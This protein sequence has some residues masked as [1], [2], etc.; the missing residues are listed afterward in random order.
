[1]AETQVK[2]MINAA[3]ENPF[4]VAEKIDD[5]YGKGIITQSEA[6]AMLDALTIYF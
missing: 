4:E 1:M 6:C 2:L 3:D 5:L